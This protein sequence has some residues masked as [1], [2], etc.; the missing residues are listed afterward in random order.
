MN[1]LYKGTCIYTFSNEGRFT[2]ATM[3][4][5]TGTEYLCHNWPRI[6]LSCHKHFPVLSSFLIYHRFIT[7][8]IRRVPLVEQKLLILPEHMNSSPVFSGVR[9]TWSFVWSVRFVDR[10]LSLCPISVDHCVVCSSIYGFW[11]PLW[12]LQTLL[13]YIVYYT[14]VYNFQEKPWIS[15]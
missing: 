3:T 14:F 7:R 2:D 1:H 4:W 6:C 13:K 15:I 11:L 5:L 8:L 12:Y 10:C 9:V